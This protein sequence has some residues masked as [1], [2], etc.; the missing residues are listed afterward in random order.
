MAKLDVNR[1]TNSTKLRRVDDAHVELE[2]DLE[3][4]L[5]IPDNT[6]IGNP[7][8]GTKPDGSLPV[9]EDGTLS[10]VMKF[11]MAND[12][13]TAADSV[14]IQFSDDEETKRIVFVDSGFKIYKSGAATWEL[15]ADLEN[16]GTGQ[17]QNL[18]DVDDTNFA[19]NKVLAVNSLGTKIEFV[20]PASSSGI[21]NFYELS[22][23][24]AQVGLGYDSAKIGHVV[25][26]KSTTELDFKAPPEGLGAPFVMCLVAG[27]PSGNPETWRTNNQAWGDVEDWN[28]ES[29]VDGGQLTVDTGLIDGD[30]K[31]IDLD[32]G[33]YEARF[34][35]HSTT[36]HK[37]GSRS[38]KVEGTYAVGPAADA[39]GV[40]TSAPLYWNSLSTENPEVLP[41]LQFMGESTF[42]M[43]ADG[44]VKFRVKLDAHTGVPNTLFY[45]TIVK[46]K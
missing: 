23:T 22:D 24:P 12:V 6:P 37:W 7:I 27:D 9:N 21:S 3:A 46:V 14:A 5:G 10:G 32:E 42:V 20:D 30:G 1:M 16:P 15:V 25:Y 45:A 13:S 28:Y 36:P 35:T 26:V 33:I 17:L 43:T 31:Y 41:G 29:I 19:A 2:G 44:S 38:W 18:A 11:T 8:F 4:I 39:N 34:W 40:Q